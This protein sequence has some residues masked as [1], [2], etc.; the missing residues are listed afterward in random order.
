M[1]P[2][3]P[4]G[5]KGTDLEVL[6]AQLQEQLICV[7]IFP[8]LSAKVVGNWGL[9]QGFQLRSRRL[10]KGFLWRN[11]GQQLAGARRGPLSEGDW[12]VVELKQETCRMA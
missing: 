5:A 7:L 10:Q 3:G 11:P 12:R 4:R 6:E 1:A 8:P 9:C 2:A